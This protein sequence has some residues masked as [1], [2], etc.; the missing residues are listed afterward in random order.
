VLVGRHE[1]AVELLLETPATHPNYI[2]DSLRACLVAAT[3]SPSTFKD[4]VRT[5][6]VFA[7]LLLRDFLM[8]ER[9]QSL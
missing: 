6:R 3:I 1:K 5:R 7:L 9:R 2:A 8:P 4:T